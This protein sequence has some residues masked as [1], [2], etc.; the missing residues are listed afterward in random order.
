[1][2][3]ELANIERRCAWSCNGQYLSFTG[4]R[5]FWNVTNN[6]LWKRS[7]AGY[8]YVSNADGSGFRHLWGNHAGRF[9]FHHDK[10]NNWD[11]RRPNVLYYADPP[12]ALW[13]VTLGR[14]E[15]DNRSEPIYR[16][17]N[18]RSR[19]IIQEV[20]DYNLLA[21]EEMDPPRFVL[22]VFDVNRDPSDPR[23]HYRAALEKTIHPGSC[24]W[25]RSGPWVHGGYEGGG[26]F[27]FVV[28]PE[29]GLLPAPPAP[30]D[31]Y[32]VR[33]GHLWYG[34]PD[35]RVA[36]SGSVRDQGTGLFVQLPGKEP[37]LAARVPDGHPTWCG[38]DPDWFF[39][40][41]GP[42]DTP[43]EFR[44][45]ERRLVAGTADGRRVVPICTPFD[46]RRGGAGGYHSIPRPNQSPD[47]TKCWF[48]SS[49]LM[50]SDDFTGSYI[51]VFRR[52]YPPSGLR[53]EPGPGVRLRWSPHFLS[54][55]V[56]GYRV[57][58]AAEGG[59]FVE[60]TREPVV[61]TVYPDTTAEAGKTYRYAVTAQEWSGLESEVTSNVLTV[62]VT[63]LRKGTATASGPGARGWDRAAPA[64]PV[65][66]SV[67]SAGA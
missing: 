5:A 10:F 63:A 32:G 42:G 57:Y 58:R 17:E 44:H 56:Q 13:R 21:V 34:P 64:P 6:Q 67:V 53:L 66:F 31:P 25:S 61:G 9:L 39:Y 37:V 4:N 65:G 22:H 30:G 11:Q 28:D 33:M 38:R 48:H 47:G 54:R 12:E 50:P 8:H 27:R 15:R 43:P 2:C 20:S 40:A 29:R 62:R 7:W 60:L 3:V 52:P 16:F 19:K 41:V 59:G 14:G 46:R 45:L 26:G 23:F 55:E 18:P 51:A 35:D 49:M 36:F 24:R 1:E